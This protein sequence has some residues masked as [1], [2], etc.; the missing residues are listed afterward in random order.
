M[1]RSPSRTVA[2]RS[3]AAPDRS[4]STARRPPAPSS[5]RAPRPPPTRSRRSSVAT[6]TTAARRHRRL[7]R[8]SGR[9]RR[10]R[11]LPPATRRRSWVRPSP[12]P[13][14][15]RSRRREQ[16]RRRRVTPSPS[17]TVRRPSA[18][19]LDPSRSTA[20]RHLHRRLRQHLAIH[21]LDH[22]GLRRRR[23]LQRLDVIDAD[24]EGLQVRHHNRG[25]FGFEPLGRRTTG[26]L[27]R[28]GLGHRAGRWQ[29]IGHRR[30]PQRRTAVTG[31]TTQTL[32]RRPRQRPAPPALRLGHRH[33][34]GRYSGDTNFL[35]RRR[36]AIARPSTRRRRRRPSSRRPAVR[37]WWARP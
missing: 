23:Q 6:P 18:V 13:R 20:R 12:T 21:A 1:T 34:H 5:T 7:P 11:R 8:A 17:R 14:P 29:P 4:P 36:R 27:H 22:G 24:R 32:P 9:L 31:C 33:D 15:S 3:A 2:R 26:D 30:V 10:R 37:A 16:V 35:D 28:D 25:Y 19:A